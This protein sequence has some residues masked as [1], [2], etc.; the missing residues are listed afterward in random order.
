MINSCKT[1]KEGKARCCFVFCNKLFKDNDFL[2]K[3]L[4]SKHPNFAT[5]PLI[6]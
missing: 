2:R 1:E 3:H 6:S 5:G 4:V